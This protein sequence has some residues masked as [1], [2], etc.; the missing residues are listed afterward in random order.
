VVKPIPTRLQKEEGKKERR[1]KKE[2]KEV[3]GQR[4][5]KKP[6]RELPY[7]PR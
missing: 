1:N 6:F 7:Y 4:N 3:E 5:I 2:Q